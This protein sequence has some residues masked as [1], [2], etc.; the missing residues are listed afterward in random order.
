[1]STPMKLKRANA[2]EGE[3]TPKR[4]RGNACR[5]VLKAINKVGFQ[6]FLHL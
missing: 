5:E 6:D 4:Q 1:M 3:V 2:N